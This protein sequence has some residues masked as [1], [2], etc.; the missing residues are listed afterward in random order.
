MK[1]RTVLVE[2]ANK[3]LKGS[4]GKAGYVKNVCKEIIEG[5]A[6]REAL[7]INESSV[8]DDK[9]HALLQF[10]E[11]EPTEENLER[12]TV[13]SWNDN[14]YEIDGVEFLVCTDDEADEEHKKA[15]MN[16][17]DDLGLDSFSDNARQ[18]ILDNFVDDEPFQDYYEEDTRYYA[19]DIQNEDNSPETINVA[20]EDV[21]IT[22]RLFQECFEVGALSESDLELSDIE[23]GEYVGDKDLVDLY[24]D[25]VSDPVDR[26]Y[27]SAADWYL[28]AFGSDSFNQ[29]VEHNNA[30][31]WDAVCEWVKDEDGRGNELSV[32]DGREYEEDY[33]GETYYIYPQDDP[34]SVE[35]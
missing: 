26:G 20:G 31:D 11:I 19:E 12:V 25:A 27:D 24:C 21:E 10:L 35:K 14:A 33:N 7:A 2:A 28:M 16:L 8:D 32:W 22:N 4:V 18:H 6:V 9:V 13:N 29:F 3:Q 5:K 15:F 34:K 23:D 1:K 17:V 30:I